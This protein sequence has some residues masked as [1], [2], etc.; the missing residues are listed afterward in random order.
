MYLFKFLVIKVENIRNNFYTFNKYIGY[1]HRN[2]KCGHC[3]NVEDVS[4]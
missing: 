2:L 4:E 3:M 1:K